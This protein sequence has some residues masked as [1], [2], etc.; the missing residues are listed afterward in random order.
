MRVIHYADIV[1][2]LP[3]QAPVSYSHYASEI[4][5]DEGMQKYKVCGAE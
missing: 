1:P 4:W 5:Y 3:P 2:H